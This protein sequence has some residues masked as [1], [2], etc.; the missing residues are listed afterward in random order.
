MPGY[1]VVQLIGASLAALFL[2]EVIK[3][4]AKLGSNYVAPGYAGWQGT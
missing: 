1:I 3:V 4:S 2:H